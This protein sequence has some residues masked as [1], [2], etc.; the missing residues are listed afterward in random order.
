MSTKI[1]PRLSTD[2]QKLMS[3]LL[4]EAGFA[5]RQQIPRRG[6]VEHIPLSF[7]QQRLWF[8][9]QL[10][11]GNPQY[12]TPV[13]AAIT[14]PLNIPILEQTIRE[15]V[16]RH[17]ALRTVLSVVD[18][19]PVQKILPSLDIT[20]PLI[21]LTHVPL[22]ERRRHAIR[23]RDEEASVPFDLA[24]GPL[25][26]SVLLRLSD[27]E[28]WLLL[29]T[30]HVVFDSWSVGIFSQ[31]LAVVYSALLEGYP[32][33]LPELEIQYADFAVWQR[34]WLQGKVLD[35]QLDFWVRKLESAAPVLQLPTDR[36]RPAVQTFR[37]RLEGIRLSL[38]LTRALR[39]MSRKEGVTLYM[40]F[41]AAFKTLLFRY[42]SQDDIV[43]SGGVAHRNRSELENLIGCFINILLF[44]TDLSGDPTFLELLR[45]VQ[46]VT[47]DVY[48]HQDVPF[49][50]IVAALH[51]TRDLSFNPLTQVMMVLHNSARPVSEF[52]GLKLTPIGTP[53]KQVAQ[54]D[55]LLHIY[56]RPN[57]SKMGLHGV[58][59][60][61]TDLFDTSTAQRLLE[62][63][64]TLLEDA[65]ANPTRRISQL[66][67]V[68]DD[69]RTL[70]LQGWNDTAR[71]LP[72]EV[73]TS[74][75]FEEQAAL[76]PHAI[77]AVFDDQQL[78]YADL[79]RRA[80]GMAHH[81]IGKGVGP[82]VLVAL[83]AE[84]DLDYLTALIAIHKAGGAFIPLDP[85]NP[86]ARLAQ[87]LEF[88][89]APLVLTGDEF[90]PLVQQAANSVSEADQ[91]PEIIR[92]RDALAHKSDDENPTPS[93]TLDNLAYVIFTSGS[94][95][96]P[97]G[98][99]I[100]HRGMLNHMNAK[101]GD[102]NLRA[103]DSVA[104]NSPQS[105]DVMIWQFLAG[106]TIGAR[107]HIFNNEVA[108][109]PIRLLEEIDRE[110]VA[111]LQLVPALLKAL[112]QEAESRGDS[113]PQLKSLR[114]IV[115][116]GEA[117]PTS[118]CHRW[119]KLYPTIPMLNNCGATECSDDYCHYPITGSSQ[120]D[121]AL[122]VMPIGRP[123]SNMCTYVL[124][125]NLQ[126]VPIGVVGEMHASGYGLGRGYLNDPARTAATF[127]PDAFSATPGVRLYKSKDQVRYLAD[128]VLEIRG[129]VDQM[130]KVRGFRVEVGEVE[131]VLSL[132]PA[133]RDCVVLARNDDGGSKRLVAYVVHKTGQQLTTN[134]TERAVFASSTLAEH[135]AN[136]GRAIIDGLIP[137]LRSYLK[138]RLPEYM[139]P[140]DFIVLERMPL[141][142]NGKIDR[143]AL[144]APDASR[145]VL[146][147]AYAAPENALEE[148]LRKIWIEVLGRSEIGIDDNFFD[149]G[150]DSFSIIS[151]IQQLEQPV[152]LVDF[153]KNPTIRSLAERLSSEN[154][155]ETSLLHRLTRRHKEGAP[156]LVC[157]PYGG[158]NVIV[159]QP[160]AQALGEEF[161]VYAVA[162]PGH[163]IGNAMQ[164]LRSL[165]ETAAAC[166]E[167]I[168]ARIDG[169]LFLYGHCAGSALAI[170]V[171]RRLE[172]TGADLRG[173]YI[174]GAFPAYV[175]K[176]RKLLLQRMQVRRFGTD[177]KIFNYIKTLGGI[178]GSAGSRETDFVV[179][180]FRHDGECA[181]E[182]FRLAHRL[183]GS[184][185]LRAPIV[186]LIGDADPLT[187]NF[188][189]RYKHWQRFGQSVKL[190]LVK[191]GGHY[192]VK[193][194]ATE[195][196]GIICRP[197][198]GRVL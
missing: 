45:R 13:G 75:L 175:G 188:E 151:I 66:N 178:D 171:A 172:N 146:A 59:E 30:H 57:V 138:E 177:E 24:T 58:L 131:A 126:L 76:T 15:I 33:S 159:Y 72:R 29:L 90:L 139:V 98:A 27:E 124:D 182:Y 180:A 128:G 79:N 106:L 120:L 191:D 74:Q 25:V 190:V 116:T 83:L 102:L 3:L 164:D 147:Q 95:G 26:R 49:E 196:A 104:Q 148:E 197:Q 115:P 136:N 141:S 127:I 152:T 156:A 145:P 130:V 132:H 69:D 12:N 2:K 134:E 14:G 143:F 162:L 100:E 43:I 149:L 166:M 61:N 91:I 112:V 184:K 23:I 36:P 150:G 192:F 94:T 18:G 157:V 55:L 155:Q 169:P 103:G 194:Q 187:Q 68:R 96:T 11:P 63:F 50:K 189:T 21:D 179:N 73:C 64:K 108:Y 9:D 31:E 20:L 86:A 153:M 97:K 48:A 47:L 78:S 158:G 195:V 186:C 51:P 176:I 154:V 167:E 32:P 101:I 144:P 87:V 44:R 71:P 119:F 19:Y 160:L 170:E 114:W 123:I 39:E 52:S 7:A 80:N 140:S 6:S 17:E 117:L 77:A 42:S 163:D 62:N 193:Q 137:E 56:D 53:E 109:N 28:H 85:R 142:P 135:V 5:R 168:A 82:E 37:G 111:I 67:M 89:E 22:S 65:V 88:C 10:D 173:V 183:W 46:Q 110:G 1:A 129:R 8:L 198:P 81:L 35:E 121:D 70:L 41:L 99:M 107:V 118:L 185:R 161:V 174:G 93:A 40:I 16:K 181:N 4:A 54:Y 122:S 92:L 133:V 84:R 113:R 34:Q 60:Y 125:D 165:E 38:E 105:F